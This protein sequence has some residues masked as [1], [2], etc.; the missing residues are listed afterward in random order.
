MNKEFYTPPQ[1]VLIQLA[2]DGMLI[3]TSGPTDWHDG[4]IDDENFIGSY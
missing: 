4:T 1:L 2:T 3:Q